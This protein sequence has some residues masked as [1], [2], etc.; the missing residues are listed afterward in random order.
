M[1]CSVEGR[2]ALV[3]AE[4][5]ISLSRQCEL[6]GLPRSSF[7]D[8]PRP[9]SAENLELLR[10]LD[11]QY[12]RTPFYGVRRMTAR[13]R[14]KGYAVNHQR[15]HRLLRRLGLQALAPGPHTSQPRP[16][17]HIY[18][19][20][21][22]GVKVER[23]NQVWS[24]DIRYIRLAAGFAYLVA[25]MDWYSRDV[26]SWELSVSLESSF[27]VSALEWAPSS[28]STGDLQLRSRGAIHQPG[29]HRALTRARDPDQYG[30]ARTGTG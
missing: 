25:I 18:P 5:A 9:E 8:E 19:Y 24:T 29:V 21:L 16:Q 7:Y 27:C 6:V 30:W 26:L 22:R 1:V 4:L 11:E 23:V 13:L 10:L 20:L 12:T 28:P 14:M 15:V 17:Q 2:R 3:E